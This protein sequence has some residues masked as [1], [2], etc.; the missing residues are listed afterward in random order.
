MPHNFFDDTRKQSGALGGTFFVRQVPEHRPEHL[1]GLRQ[2][3][4]DL[5]RL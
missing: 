2:A 4:R 1:P 3:A 5:R